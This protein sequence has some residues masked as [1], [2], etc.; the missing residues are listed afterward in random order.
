MD[1]SI[2]IKWLI[3]GVTTLGGAVASL[4]LS[5]IKH[6]ERKVRLIEEEVKKIAV[7]EVEAGR[8]GKL[9]HDVDKLQVRLGR[10]ASHDDVMKSVDRLQL[11]L[12]VL[13]KNISD[14]RA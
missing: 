3:G 2:V 6:I 9:E 4:G 1:D 8:I 14:L 13:Q 11:R 10:A 12:D 5:R 7:I